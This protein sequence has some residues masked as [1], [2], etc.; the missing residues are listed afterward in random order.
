MQPKRKRS[1]R[2]PTK[3]TDIFMEPLLFQVAGKE[4]ILY[5][6]GHFGSGPQERQSP[7]CADTT[8]VE[9]FDY[10]ELDECYGGIEEDFEN[11]WG[12]DFDV[13]DMDDESN[14]R[15]YSYLYR[16]YDVFIYTAPDPKASRQFY[17]MQDFEIGDEQQ[18][19]V[20]QSKFSV[21][22]LLNVSYPK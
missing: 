22:C 12:D 7:L 20:N 10:Q 3:E 19:M 4:P 9:D 17:V 16:L 14:N 11:R 8:L 13:Y 6:P 1:S 15:D 2:R 5:P 21:V 18:I